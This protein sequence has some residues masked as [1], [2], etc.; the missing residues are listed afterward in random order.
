MRSP[1]TAPSLTEAAPEIAPQGP[2]DGARAVGDRQPVPGQVDVDQVG[3]VDAEA[4]GAGEVGPQADVGGRVHP[5]LQSGD[6]VSPG[7]RRREGDAE[8]DPEGQQG[9]ERASPQVHAD[10]AWRSSCSGPEAFL[11]SS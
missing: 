10:D 8:D 11:K 5:A 3:R 1:L 7:S 6:V 9:G 2:N 4:V